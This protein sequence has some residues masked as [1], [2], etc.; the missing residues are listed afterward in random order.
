MK[1]ILYS[2]MAMAALTFS[3]ASLTSCEDVPA[4]YEIP[5][6]EDGKPDEPGTP[7]EEKTVIFNETFGTADASSKPTVDSY[8]GWTKTGTGATDVT[9]SGEKTSVRS[10]G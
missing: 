5:G 9:Y 8:T 3:F 6:E 7:D 2:V 10:S 4:P 1:K